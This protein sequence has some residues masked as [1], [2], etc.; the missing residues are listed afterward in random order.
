MRLVAPF[1]ILGLIAAV[2]VAAQTVSPAAAPAAAAPATPAPVNPDAG[3][4]K[5][6]VYLSLPK[7]FEMAN[8]TH[9]GR[10]TLQQAKS[11]DVMRTV[12]H[13]FDAIDATHKGYVTEDDIRAWYKARRAARHHAEEPT[14][15]S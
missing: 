10:L 7:R 5:H 14:A 8:T 1:F 12:A 11:S 2:P 6:R 13:N 15:K 4:K 9:D 3:V